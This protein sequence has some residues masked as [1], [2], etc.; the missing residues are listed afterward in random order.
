MTSCAGAPWSGRVEISDW[1]S[2]SRTRTQ[3]SSSSATYARRRVSTAAKSTAEPSR[4]P[5]E[6]VTTG[7]G[8]KGTAVAT[9]VTFGG[10]RLDAG[11]A[12]THALT[13]TTEM[14]KLETNR[15]RIS[16]EN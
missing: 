6:R 1:L 7:R 10:G 2:T 4:E 12:C 9:A 14:T 3:A 13:A 15:G 16:H 11:G 5:S 8:G